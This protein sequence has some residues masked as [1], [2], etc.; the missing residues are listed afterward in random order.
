MCACGL[1]VRECVHVVC[2]WCVFVCVCVCVCACALML[3]FYRYIKTKGT[4]NGWRRRETRADCSDRPGRGA[5]IFIISD[6]HIWCCNQTR[7][8]LERGP[9][10]SPPLTHFRPG[11]YWSKLSS[12]I[13]FTFYFFF[14]C[15]TRFAVEKTSP[16]L[17]PTLIGG[18]RAPGG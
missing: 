10:V 3:F 12:T 4:T 15:T 13:S 16:V 14:N 6:V 11:V 9:A 18:D 17:T 2:V 8:A 7:T 5:D 1:C